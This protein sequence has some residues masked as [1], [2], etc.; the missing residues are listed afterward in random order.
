MKNRYTYLITTLICFIL[1]STN[2]KAQ[3]VL[4]PQIIQQQNQWCWAGVSKCVL[5]YYGF[6]QQQCAIV[7]F[8]SVR[9]L[10][11]TNVKFASPLITPP[12]VPVISLSLPSLVYPSTYI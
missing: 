10:L 6:V 1:V 8:A 7:E 4:V 12:V 5:D 11:F 3:I 9:V 2:V